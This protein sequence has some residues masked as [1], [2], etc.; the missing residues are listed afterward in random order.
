[1]PAD[2]TVYLNEQPVDVI[3]P[4]RSVEITSLCTLVPNGANQVRIQWTNSNPRK[5]YC[6]AVF[7]FKKLSVLNLIEHLKQNRVINASHTRQ[8]IREKLQISDSDFEIETN[9]F[10]MSLKCPLMKTRIQ[11]PGKSLKCLHSHCFDVTSYLIMNEKKP[12]WKCPICNQNA[13]FDE[14][15]ID[16]LNKEI[17]KDCDADEVEFNAN[18]TWREN[19]EKVVP[20]KKQKNR[21]A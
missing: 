2:L 16:G 10:S 15:V 12:T 4:G 1:M 14:L 9:T 18:G 11:L 17:L 5:Q 3:Q 21:I 20:K 13:K 6:V 19:N 8:I 7:I